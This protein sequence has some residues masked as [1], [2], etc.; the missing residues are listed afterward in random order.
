MTSKEEAKE[1]VLKYSD[2]AS[3]CNEGT[4]WDY[5]KECAL[6]CVNEKIKTYLKNYPYQEELAFKTQEYYHLKEVE[7]EIKKL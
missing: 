6:I 5:D 4:E 7:K 1:L 3:K 2:N